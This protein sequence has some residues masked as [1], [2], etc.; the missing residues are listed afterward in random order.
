MKIFLTIIGYYFI[1]IIFNF[2]IILIF[3]QVIDKFI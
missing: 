1:Y 3:I 2:I